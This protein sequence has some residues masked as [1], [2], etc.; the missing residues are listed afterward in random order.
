MEQH[1]VTSGT[2]WSDVLALYLPTTSTTITP[3][4]SESVWWG[5]INTNNSWNNCPTGAVVAVVGGSGGVQ[6]VSDSDGGLP[7]GGRGSWW[8]AEG[9][10][11]FTVS[12][13]C[14]VVAHNMGL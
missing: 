7:A 14:T 9:G 4:S 8:V 3:G 2:K 11:P 1:L 6:L 5:G 13:G 10:E 12:G